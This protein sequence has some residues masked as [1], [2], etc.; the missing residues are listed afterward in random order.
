MNADGVTAALEALQQAHDNKK[1]SKEQVIQAVVDARHVRAQWTRIA[2][3]LGIAQPNAVRKFKRYVSERPAQNLW[4]GE[5]DPQPLALVAVRHARQR[6]TDAEAAEV[7]AVADARNAGAHWEAI[8]EVLE[9]K[10][11][12]AVAKYRPLLRYE[13]LPEE[14]RKP[15]AR[16]SAKAE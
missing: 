8:A 1:A 15:K 10:Q 5:A 12:N 16:S 3:E 11:P 13:P 6:E 4:E 14:E 2:E 9:M 7:Q